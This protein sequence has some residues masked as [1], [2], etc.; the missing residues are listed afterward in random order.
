M[1]YNP[2]VLESKITLSDVLFCLINSLESKDLKCTM[3]KD[4]EK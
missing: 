3:I 2:L 1:V 4:R